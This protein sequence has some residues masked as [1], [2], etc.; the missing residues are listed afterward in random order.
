MKIGFHNGSI[1]PEPKRAGFVFQK[2]LTLGGDR[3]TVP[4][5]HVR[6]RQSSVQIRDKFPGGQENC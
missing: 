5:V 2:I 6:P 1:V 4:T 3:E